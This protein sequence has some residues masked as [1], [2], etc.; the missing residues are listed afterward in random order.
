[1]SPIASNDSR[2]HPL[3]CVLLDRDGTINVAPSRTRYVTDP[4]DL[5]LLAGVGPAIAR[6]NRA[7]I[8]V[9]VVTNQQGIGTGVVTEDTVAAV[10]DR[11]RTLLAEW[12][13]RLDGV[14]VCPHVAGTC[15]C[16]KPSPGLL[17]EALSAWAIHPADAIMVGDAVT[18]ALAGIAAGTE[19]ALLGSEAESGLRGVPSYRDLAEL[20]DDLLAQTPQSTPKN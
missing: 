16:R 2:M 14:F 19:A 10:N 18:D 8:V 12:G 1:M 13:A 5:A 9:L 17:Q 6:L 3:R 15:D 7:G 20:V 11:M 4:A